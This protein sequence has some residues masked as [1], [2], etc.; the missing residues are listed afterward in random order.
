MVDLKHTDGSSL[1]ESHIKEKILNLS[2][3]TISPADIF[4]VASFTQFG[5]SKLAIHL[6][7]LKES[8][9][10][11]LELT[12]QPDP[13]SF[14]ET[15]SLVEDQQTLTIQATKKIS[16]E[17]LESDKKTAFTLSRLNNYAS[18]GAE[19]ASL[20]LSFLSIDPS[21]H[22]MKMGQMQKTYCRLRFPDINHGPY[23]TNYFQHSAESFDPPT[24]RTSD[25]VTQ[26]N[27]SH[28]LSMINYKVGFDAFELQLLKVSI[29]SVS[30]LFKF[31]AFGTLAVST[32]TRKI[33][34]KACYLIAFSQK[35]HMIGLNSVAL[36]VIPYSLRALFQT[37]SEYSTVLRVL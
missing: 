25:E 20:G 13:T 12:F 7:F 10:E 37:S 18:S 8:T 30:W 5:S 11:S 34:K 2:I 4:S 9:S 26:L 14:S 29:Y 22:L 16:P 6:D 28:R 32:S 1:S 15:F 36:D 21:G 31:F 3:L 35:L 27:K 33:G 17:E 19:V 23:L 24:K